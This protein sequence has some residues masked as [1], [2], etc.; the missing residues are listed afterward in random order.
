MTSCGQPAGRRGSREEGFT[1]LELL[2]VLTVVGL[3]TAIAAPRLS[4][5]TDARFSADVQA[6]ASDL[7]ALSASARRGGEATR[8]K[9][10]EGG[11]LLEPSGRERKVKA[12]LAF[13]PAA[14]SLLPPSRE[15]VTFFTDGS[16]TDGELVM[17]REHRVARL[18]V[19]GWDGQV[20]VAGGR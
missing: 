13:E 19:R 16:A 11:Y 14:A 5:G 15:E 10:V 4:L 18:R 17:R 3:L 6:L 9:Q 12:A 8:L 2:V 1:L 7:R 20:H